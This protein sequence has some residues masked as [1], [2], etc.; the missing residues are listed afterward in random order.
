M[1][2]KIRPLRFRAKALEMIDLVNTVVGEYL[3]EGL[4]LTLR[5]L[6]YQL[7]TRIVIPNTE[8]AYKN[9][10]TLVSRGRLAGLI[11][12]DAI[13]DRMRVPRARWEY[14]GLREFLRFALADRVHWAYRLPRWQGQ[15]NY[16]ELW[17]EKDA[18]AGVLWEM[19]DRFH[20]MMMVNRGY[21]SQS[22]MYDAGR[23]RF[24]DAIAVGQN[25]VL[26]YLGDHDPSGLDMVR[27]VWERMTMFASHPIDVRHIAITKPQIATY[28]P[29]PNPTKVTDSR[30][31]A[32]IA[33]H[34]PE[35]WE[36]D[37]LPPTV[38]RDLITEELESLIDH[39]L[40]RPIL[41]QEDEDRAT[42]RE[43]VDEILEQRRN[44]DGA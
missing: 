2:E 9:L 12:W 6:Y 38:L 32:Y 14:R 42:L 16:V 27:D 21:S 26:L 3:G 37:A 7:V 43:A 10:G 23:Q 20:V 34:G 35:S 22:A 40:M 44:G 39:D 11:D 33:E 1:K 24:R 15:P 29:P 19:A 18:L 30:A 36:V 41:A 25:P 8:A 17:V 5:Q 4:R 13:E 31:Q 28:G